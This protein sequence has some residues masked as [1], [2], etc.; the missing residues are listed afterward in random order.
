METGIAHWNVKTL[1][2]VKVLD[3]KHELMVIMST[4]SAVSI[5]L[6][7]MILSSAMQVASSC[8][9]EEGVCMGLGAMHFISYTSGYNTL[10]LVQSMYKVAG[11]LMSDRGRKS[12]IWKVH[13]K[14]SLTF[15][16]ETCK[17]YQLPESST[18]YFVS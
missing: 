1:N 16:T 18:R 4:Y 5:S 13:C 9:R 17:T 15:F 10:L 12:W 6:C 2:I 3:E 8:D 7:T 11:K 14:T